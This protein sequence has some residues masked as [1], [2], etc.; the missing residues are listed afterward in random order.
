M[1]KAI[2]EVLRTGKH[3]GGGIAKYKKWTQDDLKELVHFYNENIRPAPLT[4]GH[5]ADDEPKLGIVKRLIQHGDSLFAEADAN[6]DLIQ[7]IK[8]NEMS[9]I[10]VAVF[11][12]QNADNPVNSLGL[13]L[14]HVGF[15]EKG[16]QEPA[17]KGMLDPRI[18]VDV[19]QYHHDTEEIMMFCEDEHGELLSETEKLDAKILYFQSVLNTDYSTAFNIA[20]A[21][22]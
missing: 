15:L 20:F 12:K 5:P 9:G 1:A 22:E 19:F 8:N 10:S 21:K 2:F 18:S 13:Y 16:K 4:I 7:R 17:V 14:K 6:P 11:G 3:P